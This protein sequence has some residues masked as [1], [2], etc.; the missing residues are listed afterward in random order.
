MNR[1]R[2]ITYKHN[3]YRRKKNILFLISS[4][5]GGGAERVAC[6]LVSEFAKIHNVYLMYFHFKENIYPISQNVQIIPFFASELKKSNYFYSKMREAKIRILGIEEVKKKYSINITI[7]FLKSPNQ[8]NIDARGRGGLKILSERND[9][10][11]KGEE[12]YRE[13]KSAYD[14]ADKVVFQTNYAK[15]KF[16]QKIKR[17]SVIIPNPICISCIASRFSKKK[18]VSVGRLVPQKNHALLIKSFSLFH[19]IHNEYILDIYG[20]GSLLDELRLL[21]SQLGLNN[22]VN[23]RGFFDDIHEKIKDA[24]L[25]VLSS[26]FEGMPNSLMEAMMMGLPCISTNCSGIPEIIDNEINGILVEKGDIIGLAMAMLRLSED[27]ELRNK[28]GNNAM[29]KSEEWKLEKI[30]QKWEELFY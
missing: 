8:L 22:Y 19:K 14:K 7:S 27:K 20:I 4:I 3:F 26:D 16:S 24:E 1:T 23:F 30:V 6:R 15:N 5:G 12:Y 29:R 13:M 28:L 11:G 2:L 17:K 10:E 9:P 18:I 21:V 25:Y